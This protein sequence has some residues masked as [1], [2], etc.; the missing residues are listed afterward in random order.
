MPFATHHRRVRRLTNWMV[1]LRCRRATEV[2]ACNSHEPVN[3]KQNVG[4]SLNMH[5][6][7]QEDVPEST[8]SPWIMVMRKKQWTKQQKGDGTTMNLAH[9]QP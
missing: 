3:A 4:P 9:G 7:A 8:Y 2:H 6:S 5:G 1:R